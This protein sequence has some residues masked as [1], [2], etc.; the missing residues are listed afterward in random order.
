M[1]YNPNSPAEYAYRHM[2]EVS[3]MINKLQDNMPGSPEQKENI[4]DILNDFYEMVKTQ[5]ETAQK[6]NYLTK[7]LYDLHEEEKNDK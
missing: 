5:M 6:M 1:T 3:T 7:R 4:C 2:T